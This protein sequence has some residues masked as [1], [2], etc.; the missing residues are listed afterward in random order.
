MK[1]KKFNNI[2]FLG[3]ALFGTYLGWSITNTFVL[4]IQ[5][6]QFIFIEVIISVFHGFY[7]KAK[8]FY[9]TQ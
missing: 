2:Y 3:L 7:N 5:L 8:K 6:I 4:D 9:L 1:N